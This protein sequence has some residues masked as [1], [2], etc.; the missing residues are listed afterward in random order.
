VDARTAKGKV[1]IVLL[2]LILLLT[3][4]AV[5][6]SVYDTRINNKNLTTIK[7]G[8]FKVSFLSSSN[9]INMINSLPLT[10]LE[11]SN[12]KPIS[13]SILNTC[14]S[15]ESYSILIDTL[16]NSTISLDSIKSKIN[17]ETSLLLSERDKVSEEDDSILLLSDFIKPNENKAYN[18]R[19]WKIEGAIDDNNN[20]FH[21]KIIIK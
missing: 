6:Y 7:S 1:L 20:E 14:S 9:T 21:G 16:E 18:L 19:L 13:F 2:V 17:S 11:G 5:F 8:C 3:I 15:V 4:L 12:Q 10:D